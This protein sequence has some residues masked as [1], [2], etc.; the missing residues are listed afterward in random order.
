MGDHSGRDALRIRERI[1]EEALAALLAMRSLGDRYARALLVDLVS[2][3]LGTPADLREQATVP[4]QLLELFRFCVRHQDGLTT[5]ARKLPMLEPGCPQALMVQRLAD[6]W[7]A[8]D[9][10]AGPGDVTGS[11]PFLSDA[12]GTLPMTRRMRT[13]LIRTATQARV[14]EPPPHAENPWHDFLHMAGQGAP[15]DGLPPWML[16][17]D[18]STDEMSPHLA[19]EVLAR[20]RQWA[21]R[22][23][24]AERLDAERR[25]RARSPT[26]PVRPHQEY[27]AIH[28][29]R[30]PLDDGHYLVSHSFMSLARS[31]GWQHSEAPSRVPLEGLEA[32]V[33]R[34]IRMVEERG[35]DRSA[36]LWLEFVLPFE[37]LNL[38]VD[39][40][41]RDM[42]EV[43][44]VPL[45]VDY[46][47]VIRSLDRLQTSAW[48]RF[49]RRRWQQLTNDE[50]PP[51]GSVHVNVAGQDGGHLRGLGA[52][53]GD[54]EHLV[55]AVLSGPPLPGQGH[56][57][58]ELEAALRSGL[59]VV[60]WHRTSRSTPEF[61]D[62]VG[63][64]IAD[65]WQR[66]P[67]KVAAYRR[68]A[69]IQDADGQDTTGEGAE[70]R[71]T[72]SQGASPLGAN[73]TVL[74]D[75]PDRKPVVPNA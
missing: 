22:W 6:E 24:L 55:A 48:H 18:R 61:L 54:N 75:D 20:N 11:W 3:A 31:S 37:L 16:Y 23:G 43:P 60:I 40:W 39:W 25:D 50:Q 36:Q 32:A 9:S 49:W 19:G 72:D 38:P 2:D 57:S 28:I 26:V 71:N 65:G 73:L 14:P 56:G 68:Q 64:L 70:G 74:W 58:Q 7:T 13:A 45:A 63:W 62:A 5:L 69:A 34:I 44:P 17:L 42:G 47:V 8:V 15:R 12:L 41:P 33:S 35:G 53:L 46:P 52:R 4:M 30:D 29:E 21:L 10:L 1:S 27:L 51:A 59:P 67:T 66:F